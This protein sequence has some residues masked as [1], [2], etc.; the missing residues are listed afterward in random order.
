MTGT[1]FLAGWA[2]F[3]RGAIQRALGTV[4]VKLQPAHF[5]LR[6]LTDNGQKIGADM[7]A[8]PML[9]RDGRSVHVLGGLFPHGNPEIW[10]YDRLTP[11]D[12]ASLRMFDGRP[13]DMGAR[14]EPQA[15]RKFRLI[16][17]GLDLP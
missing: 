7:L 1:D 10:H 15:P 14:P 16:S 8:L 13:E 12:L 4:T 5:R 2:P 9:A 3:E 17:G 6:Y 11:A